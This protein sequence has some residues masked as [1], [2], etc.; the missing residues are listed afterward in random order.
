MS[1]PTI[2]RLKQWL[3]YRADKSEPALVVELARILDAEAER[4][5]LAA[6]V[7]A[8]T[9]LHELH[10]AEF[11]QKQGRTN[12]TGNKKVFPFPDSNYGFVIGEAFNRPSIR[13]DFKGGFSIAQAKLVHAALGVAI[14]TA[15]GGDK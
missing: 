1:R 8:V 2:E 4:E 12:I 6:E 13:P 9:N 7:L 10:S 14:A 5:R 15:E 3:A 11:W